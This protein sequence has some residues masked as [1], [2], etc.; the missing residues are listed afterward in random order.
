MN[1]TFSRLG[2]H[3]HAVAKVKP[4]DLSLAEKLAEKFEPQIAKA[5]LDLLDSHADLLD[6]DALLEALISGQSD[7]VLAVVGA[8]A[9]QAEALMAGKMKDALQDALWAAGAGALAQP[10]TPPI[11]NRAE[12]HFDRINPA[13]TR[14]LQEYDLGLIKQISGTTRETIRDVLVENMR[15]GQGPIKQAVKIRDAI[16]LTTRQANAVGNFR[17]ELE[18]FHLKRSTASWGLGQQIDR[19][20]GRQVFKPGADGDP[21]DGIL[22]RRLRDFRYDA[23]LAK[24]QATRKPLTPAQIDKMVAGYKRK[25]LQFRSRTIARTESLRATNMGIQEAFRQA[26]E[27]G[28]L[29]EDLVRRQ[30]IVAKDERLCE[31][32]APVPGMNPEQ[33]V[34]FAQPFATPVGPV[35]M[36]PIH[37]NC[38]CTQF[39]RTIE[40]PKPVSPA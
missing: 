38:R 17:K 12:F 27:K 22:N 16:G 35:M 24:A 21:T 10:G 8:A 5:V 7:K 11:L 4:E 25:Y 34:K 28:L 39:I 20:N 31:V 29:S 6:M 15:L 33:G 30:W 37:P 13:L 40:P 23:A 2:T 9:D 26:I 32:C 18:T 1:L 36:P 19:V 14:W 3:D